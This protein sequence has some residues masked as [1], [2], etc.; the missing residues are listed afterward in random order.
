MINR[1]NLGLVLALALLHLLNSHVAWLKRLSGY[2]WQSFGAGISLAYLV[3]EIL[4]ER[5]Y[6]G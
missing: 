4:P 2:R 3:G 5:N 1:L 6:S